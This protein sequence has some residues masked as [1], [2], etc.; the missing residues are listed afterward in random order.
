MNQRSTGTNSELILAIDVGS[1]KVCTILA[2]KSQNGFPEV[3][4]HSVVPS[5]GVTKGNVVDVN[6]T[7]QAIRRTVGE[8]RADVGMDVKS[9]Y[10]G[11]T[12]S[13]IAYENRVDYFSDIGRQ[14]VVTLDEFAK[15][16]SMVTDG[17]QIPGR[18]IIHSLPINYS[19]DGHDGIKNPVGMHVTGLEV[20]TH[21]ITSDSYFADKLREAVLLSGIELK[22]LVVE[23]FASSESILTQAEKDIGSAIVDIGGGTTDIALFRNGSLVYTAVI[24]VGGFQFTNDICLTYNVEFAEAEEA[25][26]RYG[27]TNLSA[28]DLMETVSI[29]PV[30]SSANIEIRRRDICQLMRERAVELIRLVDLKLQQGGLKENPNSLVYITGGASQ[31]P[32]FLEMAEQ[33]IPNCQ[34][35]R[36]IPDF[37]MRMTD[38]LKEPC[39][40]TAVGM[41]LHAYRSE[42]SAE[43]QL[44]IKDTIEEAGF[45]RRLMN[46]LKLG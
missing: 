29:S 17:L 1:T 11:I 43:R 7:S 37:L 9:A 23:P 24:P 31:L 12:G 18:K 22:S 20:T 41:V 6:A 42:N 34:V 13:H 40:A 15:I 26:L 33:F 16:P 8:I 21:L 36:G 35:R 25:K 3:I 30:G 32:G 14:G 10:V 28:V 27:H 38:E 5:F 4:S 19:V 44:G 39:Y 2:R 45:L 46:V